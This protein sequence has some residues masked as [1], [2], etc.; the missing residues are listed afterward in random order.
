MEPL[1]F[2]RVAVFQKKLVF[3]KK[4]HMEAVGT[5]SNFQN[6]SMWPTKTCK[7]RRT[8]LPQLINPLPPPF[9]PRPFSVL[10]R[11]DTKL[12]T[13]TGR[14]GLDSNSSRVRRQF[15]RP[16]A[17]VAVPPHARPW[18]RCRSHGL[19]SARTSGLGLGLGLRLQRG[20]K[21]GSSSS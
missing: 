16:A 9:S 3:Q 7:H 14:K 20:P 2:V 1:C 21:G 17:G 15:P 5:A 6:T 19:R 10:L 18:F 8:S 12:C 4:K 13:A 11:S